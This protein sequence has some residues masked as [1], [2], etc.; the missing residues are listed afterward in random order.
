MEILLQSVRM[1]CMMVTCGMIM[2]PLIILVRG[3]TLDII[4]VHVV[5]VLICLKATLILVYHLNIGLDYARTGT[6]KNEIL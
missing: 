3:P 6:S 5:V 1:V 4:P 2:G